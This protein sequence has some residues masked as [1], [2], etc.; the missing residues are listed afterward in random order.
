MPNN[1]KAYFKDIFDLR[2]GRETED[3]IIENIKS[4]VEFRGAKL[5]TLVFAIFIA[6]LGLNINSIAVIIGAMLISPLMGPIIGIGYSLGVNDTRYLKK[7]LKHLLIATLI[8]IGISAI[9]FFISP[10]QSVQSELLARTSPT[11]YDVLI[12]IFGGFAGIIGSTRKDKLTIIPGVA[13][14]TALMPPLCTIG[15]GLATT[16][17]QFFFGAMYLYAI[18]ALFICVATLIVVKYLKLPLVKY[19]DEHQEKRT[20]R[21]IGSLVIILVA[22]AVYFAYTLVSENNFKQNADKYLSDSFKDKG[23]V[24][25]YERLDYKSNPPIIEVAFLSK[26]PTSVEIVAARSLLPEYNLGGTQ[27][28]IDAKKDLTEEDLNKVIANIK[29]ERE[30]VRAIEI[31]LASSEL[32]KDQASDILKEA[33]FIDSNI[34]R[35][36]IGELFTATGTSTASSTSPNTKTALVYHVAGVG[37]FTEEEK[38]TITSWLRVRLKDDQAMVFYP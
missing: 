8:G 14:A 31:K 6:S 26:E 13:I 16:Q 33:K 23:Y 36:S 3:K 4:H 5:W 27:L 21:I 29:D 7:S 2:E 37:V 10:I 15:Y 17:A 34:D 20:R 32:N 19:I 22:P 30:K 18:N 12:A 25:I 9:Y 35:I 38:D 28:I 11:I 24:I 1:L